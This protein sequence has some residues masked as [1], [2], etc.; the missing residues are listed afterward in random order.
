MKICAPYREHETTTTQRRKF[1]FLV[2]DWSWLYISFA[3]ISF[4][5]MNVC[6][7]AACK[8]VV[9]FAVACTYFTDAMAS[10]KF[11]FR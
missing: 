2:L 6:E 7:S 11:K 3:S 9:I 8:H 4:L 5:C 10:L 1:D